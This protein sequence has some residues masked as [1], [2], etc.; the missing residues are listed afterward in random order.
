M[1]TKKPT[2]EVI[3]PS[4]YARID[5]KLQ[6]IEVGTLLALDAK[7]GKDLVKRGYVKLIKAVKTIDP[8]KAD[9][10]K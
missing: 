4:W 9:D 7:K 3:H 1:A 2:H 5:G 8:S 10:P 6:Q